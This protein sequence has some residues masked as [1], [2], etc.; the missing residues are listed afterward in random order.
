[1]DSYLGKKNVR[2]A[3]E[4]RSRGRV[5]HGGGRGLSRA[6]ERMVMKMLALYP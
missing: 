2:V 6:A 4:Q 3:G 5:T 1:M